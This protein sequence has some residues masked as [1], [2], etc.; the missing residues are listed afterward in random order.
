MEMRLRPEGWFPPKSCEGVL[1][2]EIE[3]SLVSP[4]E[5][6]FY[7]KSNGWKNLAAFLV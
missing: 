7:S 1:N 4:L 2:T 3:M 5:T 6:I